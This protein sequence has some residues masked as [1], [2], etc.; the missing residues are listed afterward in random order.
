M[1]ISHGTIGKL[2]LG[3]GVSNDSSDGQGEQ[4]YG[5]WSGERAHFQLAETKLKRLGPSVHCGNDAMTLRVPGPRMPHFLVDRGVGSPVPV[6]EIPAS[7]GITVKRVRRDVSVSVP[8]RGCP[9]RQQSGSYILSLILMGA[10]VQASCPVSSP[11]PTVP[12]TLPTVSCLPTGMVISFGLRADTVKIKVDGSWEP[13]LLEYSKCGFTLDTVDGALVLTAPFTGSCWVMKDSE[14]HL[15]LLYLD[16]EVTL[17]C[18]L[19]LPTTAMTL[20]SADPQE[21]QTFYPFPWWYISSTPGPPTA[22]SV[23]PQVLEQT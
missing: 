2:I 3:S 23:D 14:R 12:A 1:G 11:L 6:S 21:P 22:A 20:P 5:Y 18:P 10:P 15:P 9:V 19:M 17:S 4:P 7:C 13:L 16:Q 8:F